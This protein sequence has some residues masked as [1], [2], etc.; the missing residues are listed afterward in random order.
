M[1]ARCHLLSPPSLALARVQS[2]LPSKRASA[3]LPYHGI[4]PS[5]HRH[6]ASART[7]AVPSW[8]ACRCQTTRKPPASAAPLAVPPRVPRLHR[9]LLSLSSVP[10]LTK[11]PRHGHR[12]IRNH[13]VRI[14]APPRST[15]HHLSHPGAT[16]HVRLRLKARQRRRNGR[17]SSRLS[18]Q[19]S[20]TSVPARPLLQKGVRPVRPAP[21]HPA[22][23]RIRWMAPS[24]QPC[25]RYQSRPYTTSRTVGSTLQLPAAIPTRFR[26]PI[27][28][29]LTRTKRMPRLHHYLP[30]YQGATLRDPSR[31]IARRRPP[32]HWSM[33]PPQR[34]PMQLV[35]SHLQN[36]H[37]FHL[38]HR[39]PEMPPLPRPVS[40]FP[41][42]RS[43][44][45]SLRS[46]TAPL[47][48][49]DTLAIFRLLTPMLLLSSALMDNRAPRVQA[50]LHSVASLAPMASDSARY[51]KSDKAAACTGLTER[52]RSGGVVSEA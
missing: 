31:R 2:S 3:P 43:Y 45:P 23:P 10:P 19:I 15:V 33:A 49:S 6:H 4:H 37:A 42:R 38:F 13:P 35:P 44:H 11:M 40:A 50:S 34:S 24:H 30:T 21:Q 9:H 29:L 8:R 51:G 52:R 32:T 12:T 16:S 47:L 1:R 26:Q 5:S 48:Y 20:H 25:Q 7:Q 14:S 46:T 28:A 36:P 22:R 41:L 18:R 39:S 17:P 27:L